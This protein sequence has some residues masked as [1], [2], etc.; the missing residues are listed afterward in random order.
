MARAVGRCEI[1][2]ELGEMEAMGPSSGPS[3]SAWVVELNSGDL[4]ALGGVEWL[5]WLLGI[6]GGVAAGGGSSG[7]KLAGAWG[8]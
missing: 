3:G 1:P 5:W 6:A 2:N 7:S 8:I 4:S